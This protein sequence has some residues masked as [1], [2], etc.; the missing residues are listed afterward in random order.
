MSKHD[1]KAF[2]IVLLFFGML[3]WG[4]QCMR[5]NTYKQKVVITYNDGSQEIVYT[6][7]NIRVHMEG[8][9]VSYGSSDTWKRCGARSFKVY[10]TNIKE[11]Q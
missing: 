3:F 4:V 10:D 1:I 6:S 11:F 2:L 5:A 9:C 7:G 8:G